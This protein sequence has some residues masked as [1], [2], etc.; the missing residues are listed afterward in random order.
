MLIFMFVAIKMIIIHGL[1]T[2]LMV[3]HGMM[4]FHIFSNPKIIRI[5][6]IF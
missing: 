5:M 3:G 4:C 6:N 1:K 2:V